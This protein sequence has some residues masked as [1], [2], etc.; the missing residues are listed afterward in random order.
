L[1]DKYIANPTSIKDN[2]EREFVEQMRSLQLKQVQQGNLY[3]EV[4]KIDK[5]TNEALNKELGGIGGVN[6]KDGGTLYSAADL[7]KAQS[8]LQNFR[9]VS[10]NI[11]PTTF[12]PSSTTVSTD[13]EGYLKSLPSNLRSLGRTILKSNSGQKL[14]ESEKIIADRAQTIFMKFRDRGNS[15][16][17]NGMKAQSD[18][19]AKNM[20]EVQVTSGT[21]NMDNKATAKNVE[22]LIGNATRFY[23]Q[24]GSLDTDNPDDFSPSVI[25]NMRSGE[26]S[27]E[28]RYIAERNYDGSGKLIVYDKNN[29]KQTI[30]LNQ[31]DLMTYFPDVAKSSFMTGVKYDIMSSPG[32]TTNIIGRENPVGARYSGYDI[33]GLRYSQYAPRVR[34][35]IEGA[36][37]NNGGEGDRFQVRLYAF[38]G[39]TWK[40]DILNQQ[41]HVGAA[42]VEDILSQIGPLT[43]EEVLRKK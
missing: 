11:S 15:I 4:T 33:G 5:V 9:T 22:Y 7:Y 27:K 16:V 6:R 30:P 25:S 34:V 8:M 1:V 19:L 38:D 14:N 13:E 32:R 23:D 37:G 12:T 21:L 31:S 28:L 43:V 10:T 36:K 17:M 20:P 29:K 3:T 18:Y 2:D 24:F 41:G 35:D 42:G 40:H 26:G 39:N